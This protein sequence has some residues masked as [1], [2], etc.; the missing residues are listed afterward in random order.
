MI[1]KALTSLVL[2]TA[3]VT[4]AVAVP[5]MTQTPAAEANFVAP[6]YKQTDSR[7]SADLMGGGG[8]IGSEGCVI[9]SVAMALAHKGITISGA[10][11]T[12]KNFNTWL[13]GNGGYSGDNLVWGAVPKLNSSRI[14]FQGRYYGGTS[15]SGSLSSAT[16]RSYLDAGNK[17]IIAQVRGGAHWVLLTGHNGGLI[18]ACND[19]GYSN[20]SYANT[21]FT[22]FAV[23]TIN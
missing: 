1:K 13:K 18:F 21:D 3:L 16:L 10:T 12:P 7:W 15:T 2:T 17:A 4:G 19:P 5:G 6:L 11:T 8:T 20:T 23:Y 22:G 9:T 14:T